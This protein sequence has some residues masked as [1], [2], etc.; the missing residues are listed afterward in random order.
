MSSRVLLAL[1]KPLARQS[2]LRLSPILGS[3]GLSFTPF[4]NADRA[5]S[6]SP[7]G[8]IG[9]EAALQAAKDPSFMPK[10]TIFKEFD[11]TSR[12]AVVSGVIEA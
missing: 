7:L 5:Q 8:P 3:R 1:Q 6:V 4:R 2:L 11:L 12:V 9:V 10:P